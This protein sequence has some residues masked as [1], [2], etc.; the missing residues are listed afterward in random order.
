MCM[1]IVAKSILQWQRGQQKFKRR[2]DSF[3]DD[4]RSSRPVDVMTRETIDR[5]ER[6]VTNERRLASECDISNDSN[7]CVTL[8]EHLGMSKLYVRWVTR[9]LDMQYCQQTVES[10]LELP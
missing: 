7:A 1:Q 4:Q 6:L 10:C 2:R 5:V 3:E 9:N 8:H